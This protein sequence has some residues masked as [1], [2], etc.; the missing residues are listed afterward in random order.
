MTRSKAP[1]I[2]LGIAAA[3]AAAAMALSPSDWVTR[4][5]AVSVDRPAADWQA[6][7]DTA[8]AS[9]LPVMGLMLPA[10]H[11][12][13]LAVGA[14]LMAVEA[15]APGR[16]RELEIVDW[17]AVEAGADLPV[18]VVVARDVDDGTTSGQRP[19]LRLVVKMQGAGNADHA[20]PARFGQL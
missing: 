12:A 6:P 10:S 4:T 5:A 2:A 19:L 16:L 17:I 18:V 20:L 7:A 13:S 14:R 1:D 8:D 11:G 15:T 9:W 3:I